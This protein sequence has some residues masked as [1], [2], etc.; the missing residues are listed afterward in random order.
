MED[1]FAVFPNRIPLRDPAQDFRLERLFRCPGER[2]Q[3]GAQTGAA[4]PFEQRLMG[5]HAL[6]VNRFPQVEFRR[7]LRQQVEVVVRRQ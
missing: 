3:I 2:G 5:G 7:Q 1:D 6:E 4:I